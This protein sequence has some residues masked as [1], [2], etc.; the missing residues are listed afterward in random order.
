VASGCCT[1]FGDALGRPRRLR[2]GRGDHFVST[3]E[4][5]KPRQAKG[6]LA[7]ESERLCRVLVSHPAPCAWHHLSFGVRKC[8]SVCRSPGRTH[9]RRILL[10]AR[11][12]SETWTAGNISASDS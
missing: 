7:Q 6:I 11:S 3:G 4:E 1:P 5:A 12:D 10:A 9:R 8:W 2:P